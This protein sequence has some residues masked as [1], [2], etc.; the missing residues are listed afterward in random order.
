[1]G[2]FAMDAVERVAASPVRPMIDQM[3]ME[4][5]GYPLISQVVGMESNEN[6]APEVIERYHKECFEKGNSTI[7]EIIRVTQNI[8]KTNLPAN[9]SDDKLSA[10]FSFAKTI[11]DLDLI[12][13]R[14]R[15]L[16]KLAKD[17]PEDDT[18]DK[19]IKNYISQ[20]EA[21]RTRVFRHQYENI[22]RAVLLTT[23]KKLCLAAVSILIPYIHREKK[24]EA[25]RRFQA[26]I[27][28]LL[29]PKAIPDI[30]EDIQTSSD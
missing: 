9:T 2:G 23:G 27:E 4:G 29:D 26:A 20:A 7:H 1:V 22:R 11:D 16:I 18:Y 3:I 10:Y 25:M 28:P 30:P 14:I 13:D 17:N 24:E 5:K 19:R 21:I 8:D 6:F 12:Y 15:T